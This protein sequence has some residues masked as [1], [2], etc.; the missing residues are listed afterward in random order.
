MNNLGGLPEL[1][2]G[3]VTK[4]AGEWLAAKKIKAKRCVV[5]TSVTFPS[6]SC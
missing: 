5:L 3:I 6:S 2:L 4:E 1:E